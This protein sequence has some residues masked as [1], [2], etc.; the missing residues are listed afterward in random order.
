MTHSID[1]ATDAAGATLADDD[2]LYR[3][4]SLRV[5][6]FLFL[7]Y[8]VSFLDRSGIVSPWVIGQIEV[9]TGS[10]DD[11]LYLLTGLLVASG[12]AVLLTMKDATAA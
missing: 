1:A 6:P 10:M 3:K 11:A 2:A 8:V 12:C 9:R 7:C 5:V 4:I